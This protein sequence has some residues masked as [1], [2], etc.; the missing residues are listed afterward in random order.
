MFGKLLGKSKVSIAKN[1]NQNTIIQNSMITNPV[2]CTSESGMIRALGNLGQFEAI[3]QRFNDYLLAT[4]QTHPLFPVFSATYNN[5]LNK[6]VSTPETDDAFKL[7]PKN[8]KSTFNIDY[9]KYPH[10]SKAE[11]PW[12]Y[13]YRTQTVVELE[14]IAYQEYL[15]DTIDPFPVTKYANGMVTKISAPEFPPAVDADIV[16]GNISIPILLRRKPWF[17]YGQM[18]FG[19]VSGINGISID[20]IVYDDIKTTKIKFTKEIG[21]SY[22]IQL[23]CEKILDAISKTKQF[24]I[25]VGDS[26]FLTVPLEESE[27]TDSIFMSAKQW[28]QYIECLLNVERI[29]QC[30]FD[31]DLG[32]VPYVDYQTALILSSSLE[33]KWHRIETDFDNEIRCNYD[34]IPNDVLGVDYDTSKLT[35]ESKDYKI[36]LKG[37]KFVAERYVVVYQGARI[38]N[39]DAVRKNKKKRRKNILMTFKP[40]TG[41]DHFFKCCRFDGIKVVDND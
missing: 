25:M 38:N 13:A 33:G 37:Q 24:A 10:M 29:T 21:E 2:F 41:S 34:R 8:I 39:I 16:S 6:L 4:K 5:E 1:S 32:D 30:K 26:S 23:K 31:L 12:Q 18:C 35:I 17:E 40:V 14:T 28:I 7:Y 11:N 22:D 36:T 27:L 3:Q 19:T 20:I 15:G 9:T